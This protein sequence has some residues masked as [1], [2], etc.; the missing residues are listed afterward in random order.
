M[1]IPETSTSKDF[2]EAS[3][4]PVHCSSVG[5]ELCDVKYAATSTFAGRAAEKSIFGLE[6]RA[7]NEGYQRDRKKPRCAVQTRS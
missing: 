6:A 4:P 5:K 7:R 1:A 2:V 3:N